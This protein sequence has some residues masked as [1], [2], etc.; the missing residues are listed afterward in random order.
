MAVL[1]AIQHLGKDAYGVSILNEIENRSGRS[2]SIGA[3][4]ATLKRLEAKTYVVGEMGESTAERGG[5]AKRYFKLTSTGQAQFDKSVRALHNM[6][7]GL[8]IWSIG[9]PV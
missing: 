3:L 8:E 7:D 6:L 1:A 9:N 2:V 5:R 4:Y